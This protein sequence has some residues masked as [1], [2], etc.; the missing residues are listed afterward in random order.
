M[1]ECLYK[2]RMSLVNLDV[3]LLLCVS[4]IGAFVNLWICLGF[5]I[6][7]LIGVISMLGT[8]ICV[9]EDRIVYK[10]GFLL[11]TSEKTIFLKNI[12]LVSYSSD[13]LGKIFK[14]GDIIIATYSERY[15]FNLKG[16]KNAKMLCDNINILLEKYAK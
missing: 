7:F 2:S 10:A 3:I 16:M 13:L 12:S 11:K 14:Y 15:S 8:R 1:N 4:I 5:S 9:Y 6:L